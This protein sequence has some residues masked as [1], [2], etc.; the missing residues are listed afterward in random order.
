MLSYIQQNI[1]WKKLRCISR[2]NFMLSWVE[3]ERSFITSGPERADKGKPQQKYRIGTICINSNNF[4]VSG[5]EWAWNL[6]L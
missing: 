2:T 1:I 6:V 3:L 5:R 4:G